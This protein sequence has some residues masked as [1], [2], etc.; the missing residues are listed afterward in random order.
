M[1]LR[2]ADD[3]GLPA[4]RAVVRWSWRLFRRERRQQVLVLAL[5]TMAVAMS[6]AGASAAYNLA[7]SGDA[8]FGAASHRLVVEGGDPDALATE[9]AAIE[10]WFGTTEQIRKLS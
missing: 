7:P 8:G 10:A 4:R 3:G 2:R 5:I 1:R 9:V 6:V